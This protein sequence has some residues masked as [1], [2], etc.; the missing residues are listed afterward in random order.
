MSSKMISNAS[1]TVSGKVMRC[2]LR[3]TINSADP[4]VF[5]LN[6]EWF[7]LMANGPITAGTFFV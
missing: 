5:D 2:T 6:N 1:L 7:I 4:E 3:R